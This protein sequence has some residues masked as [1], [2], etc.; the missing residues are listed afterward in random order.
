[1]GGMK[2]ESG[3]TKYHV[4]ES[5][6]HLQHGNDSENGGLIRS[7]GGL[8]AKSCLTLCDPMD[9]SPLGSSVYGISQASILEWVAIA[10]S[11]GSSRSLDRA[12]IA[13]IAS[14][15]FT[16]EPAEIPAGYTASV[17]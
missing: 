13:C 10:F 12:H 1:M 9:C 6:L 2:L 15:F 8:V 11:G 17:Q 4:L 5:I 14:G 3:M 7:G 16:T